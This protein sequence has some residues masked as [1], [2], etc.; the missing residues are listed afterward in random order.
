MQGA[1]QVGPA[2]KPR[3]AQP[4]IYSV[5]RGDLAWGTLAEVE[6][7]HLLLGCQLVSSMQA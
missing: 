6:V 2:E 7:G 1:A 4:G 3:F 5:S